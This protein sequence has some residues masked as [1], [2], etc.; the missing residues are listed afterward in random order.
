MQF[1]NWCKSTDMLRPTWHSYRALCMRQQ[2]HCHCRLQY[3]TYV[4]IAKQSLVFGKPVDTV[5]WKLR[6]FQLITKASHSGFDLAG[7]CSHEQFFESYVR[8]NGSCPET[9]MNGCLVVDWSS[10]IPRQKRWV[11]VDSAQIVDCSQFTLGVLTCRSNSV[12]KTSFCKHSV[13]R[14]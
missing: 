4:S 2:L 9:A 14:W 6:V 12:D 8:S 7:W 1:Y 13:N 3:W 11:Q 10:W 5:C